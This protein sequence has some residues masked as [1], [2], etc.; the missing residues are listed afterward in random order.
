[1]IHIP[2]GNNIQEKIKVKKLKRTTYALECAE[3][4]VANVED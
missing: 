2:E 4:L 1:M 3:R